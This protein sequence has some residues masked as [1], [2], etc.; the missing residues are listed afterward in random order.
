MSKYDS[1]FQAPRVKLLAAALSLALPAVCAVAAENPHANTAASGSFEMN[2]LSNLLAGYAIPAPKSSAPKRAP[3]TRAIA[4]L[5]DSGTGSLREALASAVDGDVIDLGKLHGRM[6][7]SSPLETTAA[8]T[9]KGPGRDLLTLDGGGSGRVLQSA[10]SLTMSNVTIANGSISPATPTPAGGCILVSGTLNLSNATVT[11]CHAVGGYEAIGGGIAVLGVSA[12]PPIYF[13]PGKAVLSYVSVTHST[14]SAAVEAVAGGVYAGIAYLYNSTITGN[15][16]YQATNTTNNSPIAAGGGVAALYTTSAGHYALNVVDSTISGNSVSAS[17]GTYYDSV[18]KT[19][20]PTYGT[21]AGGGV[22][23]QSAYMTSATIDSNSL[24]ANGPALGGGG[25]MGGTSQVILSSIS[26]NTAS[27][28]QT[29]AGATFPSGGGGLINA[30]ALTVTQ[31]AVTGNHISAACFGCTLVG[32]GIGSITNKPVN[33]TGSTISGNSLTTTGPSAHPAGGGIGAPYKTGVSATIPSVTVTNSTISG[34][35]LTGANAGKSTGAGVWVGGNLALNNS[36][37]AF[38]VT[39]GVGGGITAGYSATTTYTT[40][41]YSSI[42]SN[43]TAAGNPNDVYSKAAAATPF[44]IGGSNDLVMTTPSANINLPGGTLSGDPL[45]QPL[46]FNGGPTKT[47]ALGVGS[48]A[49]DAGAAPALLTTDQ[50]GY[51]RSVGAAPDI[52]AYEL[53]TDRI[54]TNG[55]EFNLLP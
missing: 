15:G 40:S 2:R 19:Y 36:T 44:T 23:G 21:A 5:A 32:G 51:I 17:G 43:N 12:P 38:N 37:V 20:K 55:F 16:T 31:S 29:T 42:I 14:A 9:I 53:D 28:G 52:G 33:V 54:F 22:F 50:R 10:H 11:N 45:L 30:G 3:M 27:A 7:L 34:N 8:V 46:A 24:T 18:S 49:I 41:F 35:T 48:P 1:S 26:Q 6:L 25:I 4:N 47:H 39:D 13:A